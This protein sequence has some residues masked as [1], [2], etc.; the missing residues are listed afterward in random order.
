MSN[1]LP[2]FEVP[3]PRNKY[4]SGRGPVLE[5]M[6]GCFTSNRPGAKRLV[7]CGMGGVGKSQLALEYAHA[8][9]ED[10]RVVWW[11]SAEDPTS[12]GLG[13]A[14]LGARLGLRIAADASMDE[15]RHRV[16]RALDEIDNWLLV[17]D[18]VQSPQDV[19]N[20]LPLRGAG[21]VLITSQVSEWNELAARTIR[22]RE[23]SRPESVQFLVARTGKPDLNGHASKLAQ[24]LGDLP[25]AMEQ[26]AAVIVQTDSTYEAYLRRFETH[27]GEL[28]QRGPLSADHPD[29]LAMTLELSFRQIESESQQAAHLLCLLAFFGAEHIDKTMLLQAPQGLPPSVVG[30]VGYRLE[31]L[32]GALE[33]YSLV[34]VTARSVSLHRLVGALARQR[35]T[36]DEKAM[37]ASS[38]AQLLSA[39]LQFDG[40][41]PSTWARCAQVLP[42]A[43]A[44][45]QHADKLGVAPQAVEWILSN[46][47]R[48]LLKQM[49]LHEAQLLLERAVFLAQGL[50]GARH[51]RVSDAANNL[52]RVLQKLGDLASAA[53]HYELALSIDRDAYGQAD[54]RVAAVSNNYGLC[55]LSTGQHEEARYHL[56]WALAVYREHYGPEHPKVAS[57]LNNLGCALRDSLDIDGA[58]QAFEE[59]LRAAEASTSAEHPT[60][61]NILYNLAVL[62]RNSSA[63]ADAED[64]IRRAL[65]IDETCF[66][67]GHP[68]VARDLAELASVLGASG[69]S[70]AAEQ[71]SSRARSMLADASTG[72]RRRG[73]ALRDAMRTSA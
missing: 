71:Y 36:A 25:L 4:F 34:E 32:L 1:P 26:A 29:S 40:M 12:L 64:S 8:H 68:N 47:G 70:A 54:P 62:H 69:N 35:L 52:G 48:Y 9:R 28:L 19:S 5:E 22:V 61:A 43:L 53:G 60:I 24:T 57:V 73:D 58:K 18:N 30:I 50:Y 63:Y 59:A 66:G 39:Q 20:H 55:L 45:A 14:Q 21:H 3:Y 11:L 17:F 56:E 2:I 7:L 51:P 72:S 16:R 15:I 37:W 31:E 6:R 10:Y 27:W 41:N 44:S 38:A 42:H 46:A 65:A 67:P 13:F 33:R 49:R 23:L